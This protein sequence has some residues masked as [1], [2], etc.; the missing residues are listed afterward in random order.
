MKKALVIIDMQNDFV[1]G[2]LGN[3]NCKAI[4]PNIV[5]KLKTARE[6]GE[7][8]L[9]TKDTHDSSYLNS[10][11]GFNL[12]VEHCIIETQGWCIIPELRPDNA[13]IFMKNTFGSVQLAQ[14]CAQNGFN[15][16]ELVGVCTGI[17]VISN[18]MLLKAFCP[19]TLITVDAKCCACVT[20]ESHK[21]A[22]KAMKTCQI[23]VINE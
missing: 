4:V 17:C 18:A 12:P 3:E 11:E 2:T 16:I 7:F 14:F 9:F 20:E 8:I 15:E 21:Y 5:E 13:T 10:Q 23:N 19:E 6:N 1:T 22:L